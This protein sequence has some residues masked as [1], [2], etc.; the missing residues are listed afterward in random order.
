MEEVL[1]PLSAQSLHICPW[2]VAPTSMSREDTLFSQNL[3]AIA[4]K[5]SASWCTTLLSNA[6]AG[7]YVCLIDRAH[8]RVQ[9]MVPCCVPQHMK[10]VDTPRQA[11]RRDRWQAHGIQALSSDQQLCGRS[12]RSFCNVQW[13]QLH[14]LQPGSSRVLGPQAAKTYSWV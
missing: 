4:S 8:R 5:P 10:H 3:D 13:F 9:R 14:N 1:E 11:C 7:Q 12:L 6:P 2:N